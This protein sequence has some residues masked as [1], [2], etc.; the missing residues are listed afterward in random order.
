MPLCYPHALTDSTG[1]GNGKGENVHTRCPILSSAGV[2]R[3]TLHPVVG[4]RRWG[5]SLGG[6]EMFIYLPH[7]EPQPA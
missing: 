2:A 6:K 3:P 7:V 4:L 1:G 5:G